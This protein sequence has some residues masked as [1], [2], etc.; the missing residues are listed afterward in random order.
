MATHPRSSA[1]NPIRIVLIGLSANSKSGWAATA[2]LPYL[3]SARGRASFRITGL[4][5]SSV[6]SAR[7]AAEGFHLLP[8]SS[9]ASDD[10]AQR[11]TAVAAAAVAK[12]LRFYVSAA[13][14]AADPQVD[15]VVSC[16]S[17][18]KHYDA[19]APSVA[20]GKHVLVE[21]PMAEN[22]AVARELVQ[23]SSPPSIA[24]AVVED[25][26]IKRRQVLAVSAQARLAP[27]VLKLKGMLGP[28]GRIGRVV[29][30][31]FR[32][33]GRGKG[34]VPGPVFE[35]G[36]VPDSAKHFTDARYGGNPFTIWFGHGMFS[37]SLLRVF[38]W[39]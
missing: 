2:H 4:F 33:H 14:V 20:A 16:I 8:L 15:L 24:A 12:E 9:A 26:S 21:W 38:S 31:E 6:E 17:C 27:Y 13:E 7:V 29:G 11:P 30:S 25:Q 1:P 10:D 37:C 28:S 18:F 34:S 32:M 35:E 23:L 19:I 39:F 5:N 3:L 36:K 22:A